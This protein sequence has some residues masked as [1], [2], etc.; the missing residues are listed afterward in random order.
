MDYE[1]KGRADGEEHGF[2]DGLDGKLHRPR[3]PLA[4]TL[5]SLVYLA[6]YSAA[7]DI[8]HLRGASARGAVLSW[9]ADE[10]LARAQENEELERDDV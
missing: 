2:Q 5:A 8:A 3:P 4:P 7:Y 9:R 10:E 1:A 6:A